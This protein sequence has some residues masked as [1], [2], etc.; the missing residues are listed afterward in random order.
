[1]VCIWT[2]RLGT[3]LFER[4]RHEG[5]KDKRFNEI[6][7]NFFRFM[8]VWTF[9]GAWC[10][11]LTLPVT[12]VNLKHSNESIQI[13]DIIGWIIWVIGFGCE[14][15]ADH[16]KKKYLLKI[17]IIVVNLSMLDYGNI[18]DILIILVKLFYGLVLLF[19]QPQ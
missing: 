6:R 5:G 10:Y 7:I 19:L 9:Q 17:Q 12:M 11:F 4:I 16:Q 18:L 2:L 13:S 1:M 8:N 14:I 3:F 15:I